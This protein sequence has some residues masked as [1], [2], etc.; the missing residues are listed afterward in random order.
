MVRVLRT[1]FDSYQ[2]KTNVRDLGVIGDS[3]K[4]LE[5]DAYLPEMKLAFEYQDPHHY[6]H[7]NYGNYSLTEYLYRYPRTEIIEHQ[8]YQKR[9][10]VK[11]KQ[12][13]QKG[14]TLIQVPFWWDWSLE[15]YAV[16]MRKFAKIILIF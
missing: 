7:S 10:E 6:F 14:I 16:E 15:R 3:G 11:Q 4:A 1:L 2:I 12:L 5:V 8:R 13:E 9:D